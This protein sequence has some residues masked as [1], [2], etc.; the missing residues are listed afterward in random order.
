MD[1]KRGKNTV[2]GLWDRHCS[3]E[4]SAEYTLGAVDVNLAI[5]S[6]GFYDYLHGLD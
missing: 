2:H 3:A 6:T 1:A 5:R 4:L